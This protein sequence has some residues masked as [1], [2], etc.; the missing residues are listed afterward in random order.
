M[1]IDLPTELILLT[2]EL[3]A[4]SFLLGDLASVARLRL[5]CGSANRCIKPILFETVYVDDKNQDRFF[6]LLRDEPHTLWE[7]VQHLM[8]TWAL[9]PLDLQ[10]KFLVAFQ[11]VRIFSLHRQYLSLIAQAPTL[12]PSKLFL[13]TP[14]GFSSLLDHSTALQQVT[15]LRVVGPAIPSTDWG[16][17]AATIPCVSHLCID[18]VGMGSG[19]DKGPRLLKETTSSALQAFP[20][21]VRVVFR[22]HILS[23]NVWSKVTSALQGLGDE[24][25]YVLRVGRK[26]REISLAPNH[27]LW[28]RLCAAKLR[29]GSDPWSHGQR[30][31]S[32]QRT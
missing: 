15:H 18:V 9:P 8:T 32:L 30:V 13:T 27:Y 5:V 10:P 22:I 12:I 25:I 16:T 14:A 20:G 4:R 21:L 2:L 29:A 24:K 28:L 11:H 19:A 7:A 31:S 17:Y 3:A 6:S 23:Y 1:S 26:E